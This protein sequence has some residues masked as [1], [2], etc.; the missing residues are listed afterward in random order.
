[1]NEEE[2]VKHRA[3]QLRKP[4]GD[5][6]IA[7]AEWMNINNRKMN[8]DAIDFLGLKENDRVLEIGMGNGYFVPTVLQQAPGIFYTGYDYSALMVEESI[9]L[10]QTQVASGQ[11]HFMAGSVEELPWKEPTFSNIF[12]VNTMYF[13][14]NPL[15]VLTSIK[16]ILLPDATFT[17]A[18]RSKRVME[19]LPV[20]QYNFR[21][22][23]AAEV[24]ELVK[25]AGFTLV[26][27]KEVKEPDLVVENRVY[28][29]ES[30]F[31]KVQ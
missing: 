21:L 5:A 26:E 19:K 13:W 31:F 20:T 6:G 29:L 11:A 16:K 8:L 12:T 28:E 7:I 9:R 4:Q 23:E 1:M 14:E 30:Q 24:T 22:F 15:L 18:N 2:I 10:N 3:A 25:Q 27:Y 17:I